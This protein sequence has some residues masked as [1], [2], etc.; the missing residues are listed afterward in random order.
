MSFY[1]DKKETHQ[2]KNKKVHKIL[3]KTYVESNITKK[4]DFELLIKM[5]AC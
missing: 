4:A 5:K 2:T 1:L 3:A